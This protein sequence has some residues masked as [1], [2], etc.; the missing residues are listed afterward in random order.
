[1]SPHP[2]QHETGSDRVDAYWTRSRRFVK[3]AAVPLVLVAVLVAS[4]QRDDTAPA[5][6]PTPTTS[7]AVIV[8]GVPSA[9][10]TPTAT[11]APVDEPAHDDEPGPHGTS[12]PPAVL[13]DL[14]SASDAAEAALV[15][16]WWATDAE[17]E[18]ARTERLST[19]LT[20]EATTP[21][22]PELAGAGH[23]AVEGA[24]AYLVPLTGGSDDERRYA[25]SVA[26]VATGWDDGGSMQTMRGSQELTVTVA[27]QPDAG[28]LATDIEES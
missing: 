2:Q 7:G 25:A 16:W 17:T 18:T 12:A 26:W 14:A 3:V 8:P 11:P 19:V 4:G 9:A 23:Y 6:A 20:A 27:R 22:A 24:V 1:M 10:P 5:P 15:A 28:W 13:E 21:S